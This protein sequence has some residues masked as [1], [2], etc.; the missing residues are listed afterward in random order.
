[1]VPSCPLPTNWLA[2]TSSE[3]PTMV[4]APDIDVMKELAVMR[5]MALVLDRCRRSRLSLWSYSRVRL[6]PLRPSRSMSLNL[7]LVDLGL[8][9]KSCD[10][11][12]FRSCDALSTGGGRGSGIS[13]KV[14]EDSDISIGLRQI[15]L[16]VDDS[17]DPM[18]GGSGEG[19]IEHIAA[20]LVYF[21]SCWSW[22][23]QHNLP[24]TATIAATRPQS[25]CGG[26]L[27]HSGQV[28]PGM[29]QSSS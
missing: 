17:V 2:L 1:M 10:E 15:R 5:E 9:C 20:L 12:A 13:I 21:L 6:L 29:S 7:L 14:S 18:L 22:R 24:D 4:P 8:N 3:M 27:K 26:V 16:H 28:D 11:V 19:E 23:S 25:K